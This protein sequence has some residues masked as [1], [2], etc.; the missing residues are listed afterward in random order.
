MERMRQSKVSDPQSIA[1]R[2]KDML[3]TG[4][5]DALSVFGPLGPS[6]TIRRKKE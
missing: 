1:E 2:R 3:A 5:V 4:E 6:Y